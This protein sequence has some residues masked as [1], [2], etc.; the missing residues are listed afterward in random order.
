MKATFLAIPMIVLATAAYA[1]SGP[2]VTNNSGLP[3]DELFVSAPG[4]AAF[5]A[6]L[7][8]GIKEG[9]LDDG[10]TVEI[11]AVADGVYDFRLSAPDESV[12]CTIA[13]VEVK[14]NKLTL[15]AEHGKACK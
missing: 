6:N 5:G 14:G 11:S 3:I 10:K 8:E 12:L 2:T 7:M 4:K 13:N 15:T 9:A 1:A